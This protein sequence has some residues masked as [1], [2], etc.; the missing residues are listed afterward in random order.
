MS[1]TNSLP[2]AER[3][4]ATHDS[5][6]FQTLRHRY[7]RFA[8]PASLIFVG[9][10]FI[11]ILLGAYAPGFFGLTVFADVNVGTLF[12]MVAFALVL[13]IAGMYLKYARTE[14]DPLADEVRAE[15]EGGLR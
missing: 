13:V 10:W 1:T 11:S 4:V 15:A 2:D 14:L 9:W 12:V 8:V 6:R 7:Q 3:Y 5:T